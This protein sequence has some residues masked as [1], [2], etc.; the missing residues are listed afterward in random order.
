[1]KKSNSPNFPRSLFALW[2]S[3]AFL[4]GIATF[5][6][7]GCSMI[8]WNETGGVASFYGPGFHGRRTANGEIFNQYAQTAAHRD[9]PF[10]TW[11]KVTNLQNN[12]STCVRINDRGPY[13][14]GRVLDV[15]KG[16]AERLGFIRQGVVEVEWEADS[17][18]C[19]GV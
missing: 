5:L 15:S 18:D 4:A 3:S 1:V 19:Y 8:G 6:F 17:E 11:L 10:G 2:S 16:V 9:M 12:R 13:V 7:T 14:S